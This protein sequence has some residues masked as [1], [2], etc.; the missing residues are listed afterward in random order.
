[1][2]CSF[3]SHYDD[4]TYIDVPN[5]LYEQQGRKRTHTEMEARANDFGLLEL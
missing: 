1:M 2:A 3:V 5:A 4:R